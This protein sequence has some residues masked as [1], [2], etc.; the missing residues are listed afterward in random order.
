MAASDDLKIA[1]QQVS[2][3]QAYQ[4]RCFD[5]Y[6]GDQ[7]LA[8]TTKRLRD[9]FK[10][11]QMNFSAN[12][13]AVVIDAVLDRLDLLGMAEDEAVMEQF[14]PWWDAANVETE[15]RLVHEYALLTGEAFATI[16]PNETTHLP[17]L[18][19]NDP[20][21]CHVQYDGENPRTQLWA[22]K[23]WTANDGK[24]RATLY[25]PDRLE[26]WQTKKKRE[27]VTE[28]K[29]FTLE[30]EET[31]PFDQI[32]IFHWRIHARRMKSDLDP[33]RPLQDAINKLLADM[34]VAAEYGAFKQR[35]TIGEAAT[36]GQIKN[37]PNEIWD[38]PEG[39][40]VGE[41]SATELVNY[42]KAIE[43]L[44]GQIG[45]I[46]FTPR[47][48]FLQNTSA[49]AS[50][51]ALIA[52]DGPLVAKV[53]DRIQAF[54]PTWQAAFQF[55]A[56]LMGADES[57]IIP[58]WGPAEIIPPLT[59]ATI[60][61]TYRNAGMPLAAALREVGYEAQEIATIA[62]EQAT[63]DRARRASLGEMVAQA[64]VDFSQGG[65]DDET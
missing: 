56:K 60:L 38:L 65:V 13:C 3:K 18:Y 20:R 25:Y 5:Y 54:S 64:Q 24:Y 32:P 51:E 34:M 8:Y 28:V 26:Y 50:G 12:W 7:P 59:R 30:N 43:N 6:D 11:F 19:A 21:V 15:A 27:G 33:V 36:K 23:F 53:E 58:Q 62:E 45:S 47:H 49:Q 1:W 44:V 42:L 10:S 41:F 31:N 35:Y 55:V 4:K 22:A 2:A 9:I 57:I 61:Q 17:E 16:W 39:M 29:A 46:T 14:K 37:A 52:Q 63:E 40:T 48:F